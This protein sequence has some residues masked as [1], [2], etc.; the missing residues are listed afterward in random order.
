MSA[1]DD[2][3]FSDVFDALRGYE[4]I[5]EPDNNWDDDWMLDPNMEDQ[6]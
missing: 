4:E 1:P 2:D 3:D 5:E 6:S